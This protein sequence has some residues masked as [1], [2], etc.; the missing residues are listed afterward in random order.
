MTKGCW[1]T[2]EWQRG[3][4]VIVQHHDDRTDGAG[5]VVGCGATRYDAVLN[6]CGKPETARLYA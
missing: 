6:W 5:R 4:Y 2:L 1:Y 3:R